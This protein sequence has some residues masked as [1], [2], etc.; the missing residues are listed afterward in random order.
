M[1]LPYLEEI[2]DKE[3]QWNYVMPTINSIMRINVFYI[4]DELAILRRRIRYELYHRGETTQ[5]FE[6]VLGAT[7]NFIKAYNQ[8][9]KENITDGTKEEKE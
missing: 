3:K 5:Y 8:W 9:R 2:E 1:R 6:F 4:P 7:N